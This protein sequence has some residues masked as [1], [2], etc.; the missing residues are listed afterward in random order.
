[1]DLE[2]LKRILDTMPPGFYGA[3]TYDGE[4]IA[5]AVRVIHN[6]S[7]FRHYG[8]NCTHEASTLEGEAAEFYGV[9]HAHTTNSGTGALLLALHALDV[10]PGDEVI[11]PGYFWIAISNAILLRGAIPVLC[12]INSTLNMDAADLARKVT[13]KTKC[14]IAV[15]M[16]GGQADMEAIRSVCTE[17]DLGLIEDFSQCNGASMGGRKAG[18]FGDLGVTSLQLNKAI[19]AGEGGLIL[20]DSAAY[21]QRAAARS[22][23]GYGR[24]EGISSTDTQ[25]SHT[26]V[27]EGRRFNEVSA[28]VIRVQL[29]KLPRLAEAMRGSKKRISEG[30][31]LPAGTVFRDVVDPS[32]DLGAS[33][34]LIF[35]SQ[36]GAAAFAAAGARI[37]GGER[38]VAWHL[39]HAGQH[40]YHNCSNL[41]EKMEVLPGGFPWSLEA[42]KGDY[43]YEKGACPATDALLSRSVGMTIPPDLTPVHEDAVIEAMN[44]AF[45]GM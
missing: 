35:D 19:T 7:P 15:H 13:E 24:S 32:G 39:E 17:G 12:E 3:N 31:H 27:G 29:R 30:L 41:V 1:M 43:S 18:S 34:A 37:V 10:G 38:W 21:Y 25:D 16:F 22:D 2:H 9:S 11:V 40:I 26:T 44:L 23:L 20:T 8:K 14:V 4:E 6:Q 28:A 45:A 5:A 42:N 33:L 36:E